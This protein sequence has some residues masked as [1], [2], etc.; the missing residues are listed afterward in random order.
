MN[1]AGRITNH[2]A[3]GTS[4]DKAGK[5]RKAQAM[6][7][8]S[9]LENISEVQ[10]YILTAESALLQI[11]DKLNQIAL[12]QVE[13]QDPSSNSATIANEIRILAREIDVILKNTNVDGVQ[14]LASTDGKTAVSSPT[15]DIGGN[16]IV[17]DFA[18]S[19]YLDLDSLSTAIQLLITESSPADKAAKANSLVASTSADLIAADLACE[20]ADALVAS[21]GTALIAANMACEK[22]EALVASTSA[23][24]IAANIAFEKA[25]ALVASTGAALIAANLDNDKANEMVALTGADIVTR[26]K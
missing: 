12:K 5:L 16:A 25:E 8:Q 17:A 11:N 22:A 4:D 6:Q 18:S 24:L 23:A 13:A 20:K 14:L 10:N 19:D 7:L 1:I 26:D 3:D 9:E 2:T 21:T 15:F